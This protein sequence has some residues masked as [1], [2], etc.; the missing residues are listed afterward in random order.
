M[1]E[2]E[3]KY[4]MIIAN[5]QRFHLKITKNPFNSKLML[6]KVNQKNK[7]KHILRNSIN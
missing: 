2:S 6:T 7:L 4:S 1:D 5:Y 3:M